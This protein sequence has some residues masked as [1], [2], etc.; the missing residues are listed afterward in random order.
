MAGDL[1][2]LNFPYIRIRDP[3]W[4]KKT[5]LVFPHV[6]RISP[7][8]DAPHDDPAIRAFCDAQGRR[9]PLLRDLDLDDANIWD[10][11]Y[12]LQQR[13]S[14]KLDEPHSTLKKLFDR[15]ATEGDEKLVRESASLWNDRLASRTFQ[16]HGQKILPDLLAF[17][18]EHGLAWEPNYSDGRGYFEMHPLLGQAVMAALA[19]AAAESQGL[20]L[21]TEFPAIYGRTVDCEKDDIIEACLA[22]VAPEPARGHTTQDGAHQVARVIVYQRADTRALTPDRLAALSQEWEAIADFKAAL[23]SMAKD[24]PSNIS[25]PKALQ[26]HLGERADRAMREWKSGKANLS[27]YVRAL[28]GEGSVDELKDGLAKV[29]ESVFAE[30]VAGA[31]A[32]GLTTQSLY[33]AGAGLAIGLCVQSVKGAVG[34]R[35]RGREHRLRYLTLM[36]NAGVSYQISR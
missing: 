10:D 29:A 23:E 31:L 6:V 2:A 25:D 35:K 15:A 20:Q 11:Q 5:L 18:Q 19:F 14:A 34:V 32:G 16:M 7:S 27:A 28:F 9:G 12:R 4:L 33:G 24:I 3:E 36:E 1:D 8:Q 26:A 30:P 13:I 22:G 17:L 21:V